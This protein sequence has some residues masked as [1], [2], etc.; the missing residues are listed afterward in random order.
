MNKTLITPEDLVKP[1]APPE[2]W[3][4]ASGLL[5]AFSLI[6]PTIRAKIIRFSKQSPAHQHEAVRL[7]LFFAGIL[8]DIDISDAPEPRPKKKPRKPLESFE[9]IGTDH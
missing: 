9:D 2:H 8:N 5:L 1:G 7:L 6:D 3:E 4:L